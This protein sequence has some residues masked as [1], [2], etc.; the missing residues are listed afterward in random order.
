MN[1]Q[2]ENNEYEQQLAGRALS[3]FECVLNMYMFECTLIWFDAGRQS[4]NERKKAENSWIEKRF[5]GILKE[6]LTAW[7]N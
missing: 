7:M 2:K 1:E 3:S 4:K 6:L 5:S